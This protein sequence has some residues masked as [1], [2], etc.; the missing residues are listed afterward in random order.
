LVCAQH[1]RETFSEG[2]AVQAQ[3]M[4]PTNITSATVTN[5]KASKEVQQDSKN[6]TSAKGRFSVQKGCS[7]TVQ[8]LPVQRVGS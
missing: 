3:Q 6:F 1:G 2:F 8:M 5:A 4:L 7:K